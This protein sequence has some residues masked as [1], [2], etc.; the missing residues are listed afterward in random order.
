MAVLTEPLGR[1]YERLIRRGRYEVRSAS[2]PDYRL[3]WEW[4]PNGWKSARETIVLNTWFSVRHF[5]NT[6]FAHSSLLDLLS[7][8][9]LSTLYCTPEFGVI[10]TETVVLSTFLP[11]LSPV[12]PFRH[13]T[14]VLYQG[15]L[16]QRERAWE[17]VR[18]LNKSKTIG[19]QMH[20]GVSSSL[21]SWVL[22]KT[23]KLFDGLIKVPSLLPDITWKKTV[24]AA[25]NLVADNWE[26]QD[27]INGSSYCRNTS[28]NRTRNS[29]WN[30]KFY[31][32]I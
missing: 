13:R 11:C 31:Y 25:T 4:G 9:R 6:L 29:C 12:G 8:L 24:V 5:S 20:I 17:G 7:G 23:T 14:G 3:R 19:Q 26:G 28:I 21:L 16:D 18:H 30:T 10:E 2:L 22:K 1:G 15:V 32:K 27:C